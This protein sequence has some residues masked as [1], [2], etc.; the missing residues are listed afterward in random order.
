[1]PRPLLLFVA[2]AG[3]ACDSVPAREHEE[4][5]DALARARK[6]TEEA[7]QKL[8]EAEKELEVRQRI[9][10]E[11][12]AKQ[13]AALRATAP[14][15]APGELSVRLLPDG[16]QLDGKDV[17]LATLGERVGAAVAA[18]PDAAVV[19][20]GYADDVEYARVVEVLDAVKAAGAKTVSIAHRKPTLEIPRHP[21]T[22]N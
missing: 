19:I 8:A 14:A 1:M 4:V 7:E 21:R 5:K 20:E 3:I 10:D 9:I 13:K 15:P 2:L 6:D 12:R 11:L 17:T 18:D 22:P 16:I